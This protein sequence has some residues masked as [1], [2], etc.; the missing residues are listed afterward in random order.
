MGYRLFGNYFDSGE[1]GDIKSRVGTSG[2]A[3]FW[4]TLGNHDWDK[5][6]MSES[7]PYLKYFKHLPLEAPTI[8][9]IEPTLHR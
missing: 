5:Q 9:V 8:D 4:P 6:H 2:A 1:C 7:M 3:A